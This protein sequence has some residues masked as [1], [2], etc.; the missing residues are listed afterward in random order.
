MDGFDTDDKQKADYGK[1]V[2]QYFLFTTEPVA[3]RPG[4]VLVF[5]EVG[6]MVMNSNSGVNLKL[7]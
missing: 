4:E 1:E 5:C 7:L 2:E 3:D 6:L